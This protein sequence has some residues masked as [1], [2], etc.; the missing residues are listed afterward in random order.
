MGNVENTKKTKLKTIILDTDF[1]SDPRL[2]VIFSTVGPEGVG[3]WVCLIC[4]MGREGG[5]LAVAIAPYVGTPSGIKTETT[6]HVIKLALELGLI[7]EE[8][9]KLKSERL[10]RDVDNVRKKRRRWREEKNVGA[11]TVENGE[12]SV[13]ESVP[14][15][16][17]NGTGIR[18][19]SA[20]VLNIEERI[21]NTELELEGVQGEGT[22]KPPDP[23][24]PEKPKKPK[25]EK[26]RV[27]EYVYLSE[28]ENKR[29]REQYGDAFVDRCVE[30]LDAWIGQNPIPKNVKK[31]QNAA[32]CFRNWVVREVAVEQQRA[33]RLAKIPGKSAEARD[34]RLRD[35][36]AWAI[37]KDAEEGVL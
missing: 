25:A 26:H 36:M 4:A 28:A 20:T 9:G 5:E 2:S 27:G 22:S 37:Q 16:I 23:P 3:A 10:N 19:D 32:A 34:E 8:S 35:V 18:T 13:P 15:Y 29:F 24:A 12:N 31:G 30:R 11:D 17:R 21:Q 7:Y 6:A 33:E 14:E 1:Q